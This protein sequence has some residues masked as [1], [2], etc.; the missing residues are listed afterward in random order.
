M[1]NEKKLRIDYLEPSRLFEKAMKK[2]QVKRILYR[3]LF[4]GKGLEFEGYRYFD[5]EDDYEAIDWKATLRA[6]EKMVRQY[7]EERDVSVYFLVD[8]SKGMLFGSGVKLKAEYI[9]EI[10]CVLARLVLSSGDKAGLIMY[11]D[12]D[13]RVLKPSNS[14]NQLFVIH[15]YLTGIENYQGNFKVE[16]ALEFVFRFI[17]GPSNNVVLLSDF[18]HMK[19]GFEKN[20]SLIKSKADSIAIMVRDRLDEELPNENYK[21]ILQDPYSNRQMI[22]DSKIARAKFKEQSLKQKEKIKNIFK[23]KGIDLLELRNL[24][25]FVLPLSSFMKRRAQ[26]LRV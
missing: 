1:E 17:K 9:G 11:S 13:V 26:E 15:K 3:T 6:G 2:F 23:E 4:R 16:K 24:E 8:C 22:I 10:V 5:S 14:K 25:K 18:I 20:L 19:K 7:K 12:R 21:L